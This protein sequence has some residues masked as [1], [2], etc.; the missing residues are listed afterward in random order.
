MNHR[1]PENNESDTG[2][3]KVYDP[4][5]ECEKRIYRL[6]DGTPGI[7]TMAFINAIARAAK[8]TKMDMKD[9]YNLMSGIPDDPFTELTAIKGEL[10]SRGD[11]ATVSRRGIW[12]VRP[13]F[14]DWSAILTISFNAKYISAQQI[15]SLLVTAGLFVGVGD[16]RPENKGMFGKFE[17]IG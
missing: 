1:P 5:I 13:M 3:K 7:K 8:P 11:W 14:E 9:I 4:K 12:R 17:I 16:W 10:K 6:T 15:A 2:G